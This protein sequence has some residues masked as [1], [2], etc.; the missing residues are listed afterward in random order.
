M[1]LVLGVNP[2]L[3]LGQFGTKVSAF[4]NRWKW[5]PVATATAC[6]CL[7]SMLCIVCAG[8]FLNNTQEGATPAYV[9]FWMFNITNVA[10]V[11]KGAKPNLVR[12]I[13]NN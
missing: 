1:P 8:R 10:D 7:T 12:A 13:Y 2:I 4:Y 9:R 11:R 6:I 3:T 5:C